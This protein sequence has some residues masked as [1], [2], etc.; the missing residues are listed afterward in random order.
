[1]IRFLCSG[2]KRGYEAKSEQAG[3]R[4]R[5]L[6]CGA[7]SVVPAATA[8]DAT[9]DT[10]GQRW[11]P[12][13]FIADEAAPHVAPPGPA[14][15]QVVVTE[16]GGGGWMVAVLA[17]AAAGLIAFLVWP[18]GE[19]DAR[20]QLDPPNPAASPAPP[21]TSP[22]VAPPATRAPSAP[23]PP[24]ASQPLRVTPENPA[25]GETRASHILVAS[26]EDAESVRKE[27]LAAGGGRKAFSAAARKHSKD[28]TTKLLGGDVGWFKGAAGLDPA[29]VAAAQD[30]A[31][32]A[33]SGPV[34]TSFGWHL[35][36]VTGR[37]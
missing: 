27:I 9:A 7:V 8:A 5:C 22:P 32:D 19:G 2:C 4:C 3:R 18:R 24:V 29:F 16:G 31:L 6:H 1:M 15:P 11:E 10:E 34:E 30:T 25:Q 13:T 35:I 36:L 17:L 14:S 12:P 26:R 28:P 33:I 37:R 20:R 21:A 23:T